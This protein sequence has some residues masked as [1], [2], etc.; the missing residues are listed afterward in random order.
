MIKEVQVAGLPL[1]ASP[2]LVVPGTCRA[3]RDL[4][5]DDG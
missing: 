4:A 1:A 5:A 2:A 3:R